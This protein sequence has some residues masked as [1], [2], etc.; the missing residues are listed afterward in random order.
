MRP[1]VPGLPGESVTP[2]YIDAAARLAADRSKLEL[3][4]KIDDPMVLA[5]IAVLVRRA[6]AASYRR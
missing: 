5:R 3:P 1:C 4:L 2:T 6:H